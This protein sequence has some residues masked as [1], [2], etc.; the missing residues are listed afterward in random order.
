M[1]V[2]IETLDIRKFRVKFK[3]EFHFQILLIL[4]YPP[5]RKLTEAVDDNDDINPAINQI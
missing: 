4:F 5:R 1:A 3:I 2:A